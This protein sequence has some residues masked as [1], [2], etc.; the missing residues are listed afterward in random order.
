MVICNAVAL[1]L[2]PRNCAGLTAG[3]PQN[4]TDLDRRCDWV[5]A[6][7]VALDTHVID[8]APQ[9]V[10]DR[11]AGRYKRLEGHGDFAG[12]LVGLAAISSGRCWSMVPQRSA[13]HRA[14]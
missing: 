4:P 8:A 6:E 9:F 11:R 12:D 2:S 14:A 10:R 13:G 3:Y 7:C 5:A 1:T